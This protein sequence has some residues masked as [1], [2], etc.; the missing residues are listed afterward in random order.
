M[1]QIKLKYKIHFGNRDFLLSFL[2]SFIILAVSLIANHYAGIYAVEKASNSVTDII[3]DNIRVYDVDTIFVYGPVLMWIFVAFL[4]AIHPQQIPFLVK[5]TGLFYLVR[6]LF[7]SLTHIGPFP[8]HAIV[9]S[10]GLFGYLNPGAD[11]F[12][13]GHTGLPVLLALIFWENK[14]LRVLFIILSLVFGVVVLL[15]HLHYS[16]DVLSAFFISYGIYRIAEIIFRKDRERFLA[17]P[18]I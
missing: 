6:S 4:V 5:T 15:G 8:T 10:T 12:F 17:S 16:I 11:L 7:I 9:Q 1:E 18:Q 3:L 2:F 14:Y 13:S